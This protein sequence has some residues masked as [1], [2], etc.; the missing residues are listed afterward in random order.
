[1]QHP[2]RL[3]VL[4]QGILYAVLDF[5]YSFISDTLDQ[6]NVMLENSFKRRENWQIKDCCERSLPTSLAMVRF[7]SDG[8]GWMKKRAEMTGGVFALDGFHIKK[9]VKRL[10]RV[11]GQEEKRCGSACPSKDLLEEWRE[12][13]ASAEKRKEGSVTASNLV[14]ERRCFAWNTLYRF[15]SLSRLVWFATS[16]TNGWTVIS[17]R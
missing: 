1:M 11:L 5:G 15:S 12:D 10:C 17:S 6:C 4:T 7:Q 2:D 8:G 16:S 3:E 14:T 9:H 13:G